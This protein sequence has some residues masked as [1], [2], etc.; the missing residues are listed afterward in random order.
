MAAFPSKYEG[1]IDIAITKCKQE[2][3]TF[4]K[5]V[6]NRL[7]LESFQGEHRETLT[8]L[9][10]RAS[11]LERNELA[12]LQAIYG[13]EMAK[14]IL[15]K[16]ATSTIIG[17]LITGYALIEKVSQKIIGRLSFEGGSK[18]GESLCHLIIAE[19]Y[20]NN[21]YG[22]EAA[23]LGAALALLICSQ[24]TM[25]GPFDNQ[26]PLKC[27]A[28]S[29]L[30][31]NVEAVNWITKMGL[32]AMRTC[33]NAENGAQET[34][35]GIESSDLRKTIDVRIMDSNKIDLRIEVTSPIQKSRSPQSPFFLK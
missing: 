32:Q 6:G 16:D 31:S 4:V 25:V 24:N 21:G 29:V 22:R 33:L 15:Q 26:A 9:F 23:A 12:D 7:I 13:E 14:K 10:G 27:I 28:A 8:E 19:G 17:N 18:P 3:A 2:A 35:Y 5:G 11:A 34:V 1:N 20:R 30:N